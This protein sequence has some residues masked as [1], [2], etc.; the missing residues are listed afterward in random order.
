MKKGFIITTRTCIFG[1]A[2]VGAGSIASAMLL[3]ALA[4]Y[5]SGRG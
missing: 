1:L 4:A 3:N 5:D 2:L